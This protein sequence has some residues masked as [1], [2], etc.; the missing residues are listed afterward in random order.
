MTSGG[1]SQSQSGPAQ[2]TSDLKVGLGLSHPAYPR[3]EGP[4]SESTHNPSSTPPPYP[5]W[6][7]LAHTGSV[8]QSKDVDRLPSPPLPCPVEVP[9]PRPSIPGRCNRNYARPGCASVTTTPPT[10]K[11]DRPWTQD[12]HPVLTLECGPLGRSTE[13]DGRFSKGLECPWLFRAGSGISG[14]PN[15]VRLDG[16]EETRK[17][18]TNL[19][20]PSSRPESDW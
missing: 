7:L 4:K 15:D 14:R 11:K 16:P 18:S 17:K 13:H 8:G 20:P 3:L 9:L 1:Q 5:S 2:S 10:T 12:P 6:T 19:P